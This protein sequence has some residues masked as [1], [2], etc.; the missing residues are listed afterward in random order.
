MLASRELEK[1]KQEYPQLVITEIDVLLH[2]LTALKDNVR[3]IP[4]L[5]AGEQV[6][7]GIFLSG[8]KIRNFIENYLAGR[9]E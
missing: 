1:L 2:P 6:L 5:K 8:K 3:M 4:T 7:S 9:T